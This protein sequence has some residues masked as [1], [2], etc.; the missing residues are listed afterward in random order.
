M[1][2]RKI[3]EPWLSL[4]T[5]IDSALA[6]PVEIVCLGG[7]VLKALYGIPRTT[8]DLDYVEVRPS[9]ADKVLMDLAGKGSKLS[10]KHGVYLQNVSSFAEIPDGYEQRLTELAAFSHLRVLA[11]DAIDLLLSKLGRNSPKD[12]EDVRFV[13]EKANLKFEDVKA[14]FDKEMKPWIPN[15]DR[16]ELTLEVVWR[17]LLEG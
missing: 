16:H 9:A 2:L 6:E 14:R 13:A 3:P 11:P 12:R 5:D 15:V 17:D 1:T 8:A 10:K 7:F 4:L